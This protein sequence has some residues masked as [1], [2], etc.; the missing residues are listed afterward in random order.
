MANTIEARCHICGNVSS[1]DEETINSSTWRINGSVIIL[2]CPCED[3]LLKKI[4]RVHG[5]KIDMESSGE[6]T[7]ITINDS[8]IKC[9]RC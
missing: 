6:I 4:A 9:N 2:C 8:S 5:I 3:D 7:K 1:Y